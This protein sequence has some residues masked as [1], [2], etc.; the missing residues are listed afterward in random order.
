MELDLETARRLFDSG[1]FL[2][3]LRRIVLSRNALLQLPP[4][5]R[6]V[7]A[8]AL[9]YTGKAPLASELVQSILHTD[10]SKSLQSEAH[11]VCGLIRKRE[12]LIDSALVEFQLAARLAKE[13][14]DFKGMAWAQAHLFRVLVDGV[15]EPDLSAMFQEVRRCVSTAGDSN[16]AAFLHDS[17]ALMEAQKGRTAEAA[18]HLRAARSLL[19]VQSNA[20][21][22]QLVAINCSCV[23]LIDCD[24]DAFERFASEGRSLAA[25]TG[26]VNSD[27]VMDTNDAHFALLRG[28]FRKAT[29]LLNKILGSSA[30]IYVQLAA[31][32]G[33]ARVL[34][35]TGELEKCKG[36]L[37]RLDAL[38]ASRLQF[39][40][41]ARGAAVLR[42]K[43]LLRSKRWEEAAD[44]AGKD[45]VGFAAVNDRGAEVA[46]R[47]LRAIASS[48]S[49]VSVSAA[50]LVEARMGGASD[51]REYQADY[52][53]AC[54]L[55][56]SGRS[57]RGWVI[58]FNARSRRVWSEQKNRSGP[59]EAQA[60]QEMIDERASQLVADASAAGASVG[61][62]INC[63]AA[64]FDLA[65]NPKLLGAELACAVREVGASPTTA[66]VEA[67]DMKR[68]GFGVKARSIRLGSH[69][70]R[71]LNFACELP[72]DPAKAIVLSDILRLG[73]AAVE[74]EQAREE[75]RNRAALWPADPVETSSGAIFLAEEMQEKLTVARRIAPT[76]VPVLITGVKRRQS[77]AR[78]AGRMP[79]VRTHLIPP[80]AE[81]VASPLRIPA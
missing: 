75:R 61:L 2:G 44:S 76:N 15:P 23:A 8:H 11:L 26:H 55:I 65:Y 58:E 30:G 39:A 81:R 29:F 54:A 9:V 77:K 53:Q 80:P 64:A 78:R 51:L 5:V 20:W 25:I 48:V 1:Q 50:D 34:L 70:G 43:W 71:D 41:S 79:A 72:A 17:V 24:T 69:N 46:L 16:V 38:A 63:V 73:Q 22:E 28:E 74:L 35:A 37:G 21:I 68:L 52:Y 13:A 18:R 12:G 3:V 27:L 7:V 49:D 57:P 45:L 6:A 36:A 66:V 56:L 32:E 59:V 10:S 60:M 47:M 42:A 31:L 4:K 33:F 19:R 14:G 40:Y 67:K 62:A